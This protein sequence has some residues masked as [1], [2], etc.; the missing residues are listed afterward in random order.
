MAIGIRDQPLT[1]IGI[2]PA[3]YASQRL[4]AKPLIDLLGKPMVQRV[5]EQAMKAR[6]LD[7]VIV[8]TDDRRIEQ[9]VKAF[10]GDVLMTP[11]DLRSGSDRVAAVAK[12]LAADMYVNIQG[13]EP[14]IPPGLIDEA[15]ET[16][17]RD[18]GAVVGTMARRLESPADLSN[19]GVVK[20]VFDRRG[21]AL[22]F[23]RSP[24]PHVRDESDLTRWP[25]SAVIYK[26]VGIYVYRREFLLRFAIMEESS[27]ERA[28]KL[29]QLRILEAGET[30]AVGTTVH[31]SI[32]VDTPADIDR[33]LQILKSSAS[34]SPSKSVLKDSSHG[35]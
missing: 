35:S 21:H 20:V 6:K 23:S 34:P 10:G 13:D 9:A 30:I 31:D 28:E 19:P 15:V 12:S 24:I 7:R 26:H 5:Y 2:I 4:P 22:Y 3:R 8:A 16:L 11:A 1:T 25:S 27:L 33:V 32:P 14:L 18:S 17:E 29:E